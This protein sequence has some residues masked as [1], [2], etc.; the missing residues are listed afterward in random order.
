GGQ[1]PGTYLVDVLLNG[2]PVDSREVVF[3]QKEDAR[4]MPALQACLS[5][6]QL[7]HYGVKTEDYHALSGKDPDADRACADIRAIPDAR[8]DFNFGRQQLMLS[9][10]QIALRPEVNGL[11]PRE[12]WNEGVPAVLM[13]YRAGT[14]RMESRGGDGSVAESQHLELEP[15]ANWGP[16]R[17]RNSTMWQKSSGRSGSWQTPYTYLERGLY[18]MRSRLTLGE[19][20]TPSGIFDSVP[21]RGV[22]LES[23]DSMLPSSPWGFSPVVR[24]IART[25]ARVE[26][27]QNGYTVYNA[28]VPPGPFALSNFNKGGSGG[29]LQVTVREADGSTQEFNVPYQTPAIA[30]KEGYREYNLMAGQYRA[31]DNAVD[32]AP[33]AQATVMYGLPW[34][35]TL[36]S[37]LQGAQHYQATSAGMGMSLGSW[38]AVSLDG[39][40][41]RWQKKE[42]ERETGGFGRL[43]YSKSVEA[44][45][46]YITLYSSRYDASGFRQL[47]EVL[48]S[49]R[50]GGQFSG[51]A[52]RLT[53]TGLTLAQSLGKLGSLNLSA[54]RSSYGN[55]Q[56]STT[57]LSAGYGIDIGGVSLSLNATQNRT[58]NSGSKWQCNR[59]VSVMVSVPM[60]R[61]LGGATRATYQAISPSSGGTMHQVG[62]SGQAYKHQLQWSVNQR[63]RSGAVSGD[64][65]DSDLNLGWSGS[66]GQ[67]N[68]RYGY[69]PSYQQAGVDASGG[70]VITR[71]GVTAGQ[72]LNGTVAL[73]EAAGASA[74][75]VRGWPG[76]KT[77]FR[78]YTTQSGLRPYQ[79]NIVSL[80]PAGLSANAEINNTDVT[81]VPTQGAVIPATFI[82]HIGGRA[83]VT[84]IRPDGKP[85]PFGALVTP[86]KQTSSGS[87]IT[88]EGGHV[89]LSGLGDKGGLVARWAGTQQCRADY[90][91]PEKQGA[92]GLY[93]LTAMCY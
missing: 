57:S 14:S 41:G 76:V 18:D 24:G 7:S 62:L 79:K 12:Q 47:S 42:H 54:Y 88:D 17:L 31:S 83:L 85:V 60:D 93:L 46:T 37:G 23:D 8:A 32:A 73:V 16:W 45:N 65:N 67:L 11:V 39:T 6:E 28:T 52:Q 89:Y 19:R 38:G 69:S 53:E 30:L 77:D 44:T 64:R 35:L 58:G 80:D 3:H 27:K 2:E 71:S 81:V 75:P 78:G 90:R 48:D 59:L 66:Y 86:E 5:W 74:V 26:V 22:M 68:V 15:G 1:L 40:F 51:G 49:Y 55:G 84:L 56:G 43:R 36:Y 91:L 21:F 92:A 63:Q 87:G 25:Q 82:T 13:N 29:D 33:V 20:F 9:I 72:I 50:Q 4:G 61:W 70:I 10:P 34:G